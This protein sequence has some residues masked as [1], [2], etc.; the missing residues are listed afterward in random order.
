M[1][2]ERIGVEDARERIAA[3]AAQALDARA[4][5]EFGESHIPGATPASEDDIQAV[6]ADLDAGK[7]VI[8][9]S[10]GDLP[11]G[12]ARALAD[13][14]FEVAVLDGGMSAWSDAG[15]TVQPTDD[16]G[17][18][19]DVVEESAPPDAESAADQPA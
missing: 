8:V 9:V 16:L 18:G 14:G 13:G 19:D 12:I 4:P 11:D 17:G 3:G 1:T 7:P 2:G 6:I 15:F 10:D 5:D